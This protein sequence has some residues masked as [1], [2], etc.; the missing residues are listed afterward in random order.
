L[1]EPD[2]SKF[3]LYQKETFFI[4]KQFKFSKV[5]LLLLKA[6]P[7]IKNNQNQYSEN[8]STFRRLLSFIQQNKV[9]LQII[10]A[11]LSKYFFEPESFPTSAKKKL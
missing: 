11:S 6:K 2:S 3:S 4:K 1:H 10:K 5:F 9:L 8:T 7:P